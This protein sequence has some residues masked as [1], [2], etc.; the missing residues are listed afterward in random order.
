MIGGELQL[1]D[2]FA[3]D[4]EQAAGLM[5]VAAAPLGRRVLRLREESDSHEEPVGQRQNQ[6]QAV[7][8]LRPGK[9]GM[10]ERPARAA[11][12]LVAEELFDRHAAAVEIG[13]LGNLVRQVGHQEPALVAIGGQPFRPTDS[14]VLRDRVVLAELDVPEQQPGPPFDF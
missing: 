13:E 9:L 14:H 6:E 12:L 4:E 2:H 1:A 11:V 10:A 5:A 3:A 8:T 7:E